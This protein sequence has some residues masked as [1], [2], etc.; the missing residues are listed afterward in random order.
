MTALVKIV[1][2]VTSLAYGDAIGDDVLAMDRILKGAGYDCRVMAV[3]VDDRLAGRA[4]NVDFGAIAPDDLII[5]H[6]ATGDTLSAPICKLRCQ[7][8][9]VYHNI[10]PARFFLPYDLVMAWNLG[11]GRRQLKRLAA[12][13]DYACGDSPSAFCGYPVRRHSRRASAAR[14]SFIVR[15]APVASSAL[16]SLRAASNRART[17]R[18]KTFGASSSSRIDA[19]CGS[20]NPCASR[21]ACASRRYC[22][23]EA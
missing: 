13:A 20:R 10:T 8:M 17:G 18:G 14:R 11:R 16:A 15:P 1:Q 5:F 7:K 6:K 4:E 21:N 2:F 19:G 23:S 3:I 22:I 9:V 12:V